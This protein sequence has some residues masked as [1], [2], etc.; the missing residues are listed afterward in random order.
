MEGS[1]KVKETK[2]GRKKRMG[3]ERWRGSWPENTFP[4]HVFS[5]L[6]LSTIPYLLL[7]LT[8]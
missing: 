4:I 6:R 3:G 2:K 5:G 7:F 1:S 8:S